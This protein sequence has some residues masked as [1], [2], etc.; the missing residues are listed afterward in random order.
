MD[1]KEKVLSVL[2]AVVPQTTKRIADRARAK[3]GPLHDGRTN[4]HDYVYQK[5]RALEA[6]GRVTRHGAGKGP[7][8]RWTEADEQT[9]AERRA[10][11]ALAEGV[12]GPGPT[13][14][15]ETFDAM[16]AMRDSINEVIPM[17]SLESDLLQGPEN[18]V[19]CA[20]VAEAV[21]AHVRAQAEREK[22][23]YRRGW[24]FAFEQCKHTGSVPDPDYN[25][26]W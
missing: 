16:C 17:P 10:L 25:P 3:F 13:N 5:L 26:N 9:L 18:S 14:A 11:R 8:V 19:F 12:N 4:S 24:R 20:A 22:E 7:A 23:A 21:V 2:S 1:A 6:E 15:R